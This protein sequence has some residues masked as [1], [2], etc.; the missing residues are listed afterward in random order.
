MEF[1]RVLFRSRR[2][3]RGCCHQEYRAVFNSR[4]QRILLSFGKA[5][6]LVD[7][8]YCAYPADSLL[9]GVG[10]YFSNLF[11][12]GVERGQANEILSH[13]CSD[14]RAIRGFAGAERSVQN[15]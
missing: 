1:R 10:D 6:Y 3:F 13:S 2:V 12:P 8:K 9:A 14:Q 4:E 7:E 5:V 15:D 11:D